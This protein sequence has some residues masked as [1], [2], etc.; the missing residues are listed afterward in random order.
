MDPSK[1]AEIFWRV[2]NSPISFNI[3]GINPETG[4]SVRIHQIYQ[5]GVRK[6]VRESFEKNVQTLLYL[7]DLKSNGEFDVALLKSLRKRD[8]IAVTKNHSYIRNTVTCK[9]F[10]QASNMIRS[11]HLD[12]TYFILY[13]Q[14]CMFRSPSHFIVKKRMKQCRHWI[15]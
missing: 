13:V 4:I 10:L 7:T 14:T 12:K 9:W 1:M 6:S 8:F 11:L 5:E 15:S 2:K 3:F